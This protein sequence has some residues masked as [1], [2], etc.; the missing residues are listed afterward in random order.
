MRTFFHEA[1]TRVPIPE[2]K[3]IFLKIIEKK[4]INLVKL[5]GLG[6]GK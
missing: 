1:S 5:E 4:E 2:V 6:L 3:M